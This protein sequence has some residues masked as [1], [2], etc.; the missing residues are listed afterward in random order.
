MKINKIAEQILEICRRENSDPKEDKQE[1]YKLYFELRARDIEKSE[2]EVEALLN[3]HRDLWKVRNRKGSRWEHEIGRLIINALP[4]TIINEDKGFDAKNPD[5]LKTHYEEHEEVRPALRSSGM[6]LKYAKEVIETKPDKS[7][8]Y[9]KR[10][11][12]ALRWLDELNHYFLIEGI[13]DIFMDF[14]QHKDEDL[15]FFALTGLENHYGFHQDEK[16]SKKEVEIFKNIIETTKSRYNAVA[17]CQVLVHSGE[18]ND[19]DAMATMDEWKGRNY[20]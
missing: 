13:R 14:I 18:Y 15:Q 7:K 17:A 9:I 6:L 16:M 8:R 20:N 4:H 5:V 10:I 2:K 3:L 12:E 1:V 11:T 19:W